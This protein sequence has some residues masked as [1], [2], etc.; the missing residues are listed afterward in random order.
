MAKKCPICGQKIGLMMSS[1]I[2]DGIIC[3]SCA[4]ICSSHNTKTV[5]E[6]QEF[7]GINEKRKNTF[8]PTQKLKSFMS[9]TITLD[10]AN[11]LFVFGDTSK[12]K[13]TPIYYAYDEI[14]SYEIETVGQK[15]VTKKKGGITRAIVGGTVAG[16]IGALV[17]S[18]TAKEESTVKGGTQILK[19]NFN[20]YSCFNQ[21][22][23]TNP[24]SGFV[25]FLQDCINNK[26]HEEQ[27]ET[28]N[29]SFDKI[30]KYKELLDNGIIT[31]EEFE[32]KKKELLNL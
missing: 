30:V 28:G 13:S 16:P 27:Q 26:Q 19:V 20:T 12:M 25:N 21:R 10:S 4:L 7:W 3:S 11:R 15:T 6:I 1:K 31:I 17:G 14:D 29:D 23:C 32:I 24:P 18:E 8:I 9:E 5:R 2:S 22:V